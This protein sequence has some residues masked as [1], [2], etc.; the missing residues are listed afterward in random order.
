MRPLEGIRDLL[1]LPHR[2]VG[3]EVDRG[4][5]T[6][7]T[8]VECTIHRAEHHLIVCRRVGQQLVVIDLDDEGDLVGVLAGHDP[9]HAEGRGNSIAAGLDGQLNDVRWVEVRGIRGKRRS[10]RVLDALVDRKDR[11]VAGAA[12]P[13]VAEELLEIPEHLGGAVTLAVHPV[14]DVGTRKREIFL[15]NALG[16]VG[17]KCFGLVTEQS[18]QI[19][20]RTPRTRGVGANYGP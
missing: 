17:Q 4:T 20:V 8:Q 9:E 18:G 5:D 19:H 10:R 7:R 16:L 13:A 3:P 12:Q 6:G 15:G 11:H 14:D 2:V 1:E